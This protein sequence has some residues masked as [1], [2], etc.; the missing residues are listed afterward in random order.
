M[1]G[2]K[3]WPTPGL[4]LGRTGGPRLMTDDRMLT[5]WTFARR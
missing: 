3:H 2:P 4:I 1:T 5:E